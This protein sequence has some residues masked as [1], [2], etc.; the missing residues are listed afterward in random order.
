L[1]EV[2]ALVV[3]A[4]GARVSDGS[5]GSHTALDISDGN[6]LSAMFAVAIGSSGKSDDKIAV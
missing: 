4:G 3:V 1:G 6:L 2:K 5:N